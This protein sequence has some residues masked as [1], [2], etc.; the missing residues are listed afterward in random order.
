M[1]TINQYTPSNFS[2]QVNDQEA[3]QCTL[4]LSQEPLGL[5]MTF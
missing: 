4:E 3:F 5:N 1:F 2:R